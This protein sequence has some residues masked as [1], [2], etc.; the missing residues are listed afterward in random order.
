MPELPEVENIA[1]G[2]RNEIVGLRIRE[3]AIGNPI[4]VKGRYRRSWR[5]AARQLAGGRITKV[6]R[7]AKRLI[8][9]TNKDLA[10][11]VQ[12]GMTGKFLLSKPEE[13]KQK[14][15][16]FHIKFNRNKYLWYLDVRR[17][18]RIW[19]LEGLMHDNFDA[20]MEESGLGQLGPEPNSIKV[21]EFHALLKSMRPIKSLL[22]DQSKIAGLGNIY[23]DE[24]LFQARIYP[25]TP[26]SELNSIQAND[27]R[28]SIRTVIRK[29]IA[30][31]GT[32][33]SDFRNAYG[34]MGRFRKMLKVYRRTG[35]PCRRCRAP[36]ERIRI[37]GR[38][39]HFCPKCQ[40]VHPNPKH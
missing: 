30:H 29:A 37:G 38:S 32:T 31:G 19:F 40:A 36:I 1:E 17:F 26:A 2:L 20:V 24:S 12:L 23:A 27:L 6:S 3:L 15:I 4:I 35:E 21:K 5:K 7:R 22:L 8:L 13:V 39:T 34:D 18:G 11:L 25:G 28:K 33:F 16:R 10:I 9:F 14:H